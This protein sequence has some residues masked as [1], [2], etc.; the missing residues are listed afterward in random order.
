MGFAPF[1]QHPLQLAKRFDR[2]VGERVELAGIALPV[3]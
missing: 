2:C 3:V 1:D